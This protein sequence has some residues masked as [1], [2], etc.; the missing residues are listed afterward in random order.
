MHTRDEA[1]EVIAH[2]NIS[3]TTVSVKIY[4]HFEPSSRETATVFAATDQVF[5]GQPKKTFFERKGPA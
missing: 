4:D 1:R 2:Q 5:R 3:S